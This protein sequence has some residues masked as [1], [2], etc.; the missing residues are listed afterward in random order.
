MQRF[1]AMQQT[2]REPVGRAAKGREV[3]ASGLRLQVRRV[4][5][6]W[7][8]ATVQALAA[9][10]Q[11]GLAADRADRSGAQFVDALLAACQ[12]GRRSAAAGRRLGQVTGERARGG[13]TRQREGVALQGAPGARWRGAHDSLPVTA[14]DSPSS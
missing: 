10:L 7:A 9:E 14:K 2:Q 3:C 5:R 12:Q 4:Q 13:V 1:V 6:Q 11:V 8:A